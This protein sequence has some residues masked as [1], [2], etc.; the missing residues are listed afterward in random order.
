MATIER[1][2]K[3]LRLQY[4]LLRCYDVSQYINK[5]LLVQWCQPKLALIRYQRLRTLIV[6]FVKFSRL[7]ACLCL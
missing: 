6:Q 2:G 7:R 5:T 3:V 4:L 1:G